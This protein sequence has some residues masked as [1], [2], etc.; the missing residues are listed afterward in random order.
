[1]VNLRQLDLN[2]LVVFD[3]VYTTRSNTRA[4]ERLGLTQSAVSNALRRLREHID[5]PLFVREG[6]LFSPSPEAHR[7]A[8][9]I[10]QALD[11]IEHSLGDMESFD[12]RQRAREF[13]IA[14]PDSLEEIVL[15]PLIRNAREKGH[16]ISFRTTPLF[17]ADV[18]SKLLDNALDFGFLPNSIHDEQ[19][20]SAYLFDEDACIISSADHAVFAQRDTFSLEDMSQAG[21]CSLTEE[22]RRLTHVESEMQ[23]KA[24][25]RNIVCT[26][27]RLWSIPAIVGST[28]LIAAVP[29][30]M[31][32]ANKERYNLKIFDLP[33]ERP[34]HHW[35]LVWNR[36][37]SSDPAL[38]WFREAVLA[39]VGEN[40]SLNI[41]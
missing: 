17:Q 21:L 26:V 24:V 41:S 27:S 30:S 33:L 28:D 15:V 39:I 6:S 18:R 10:R 8:P 4:A 5:D 38:I 1:M 23:A 34:T 2:L 3:T 9:I 31:A 20:Q 36:E 11:A 40:A 7:I 35:H 37:L 13:R 25:K 14:L 16:I 29:R 19:I 12:P 32:E 22:V